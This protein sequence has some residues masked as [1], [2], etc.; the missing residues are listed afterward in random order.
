MQKVAYKATGQPE[1]DGKAAD[2]AHY[3]KMTA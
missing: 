3:D 1:L 2:H